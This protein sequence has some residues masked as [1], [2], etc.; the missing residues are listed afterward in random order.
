MQFFWSGPAQLKQGSLGWLHLLSLSV[1]WL[2]DLGGTQMEHLASAPHSL[3]QASLYSDLGL[4]KNSKRKQ[5]QYTHIFQT[6]VCIMFVN[7]LQAKASYMMGG[8]ESHVAK[9]YI[10]KARD[11]ILSIFIIYHSIKHILWYIF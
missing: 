9:E 2:I 8:D 5:A 10:C 7:V 11:N 3:A 4:P 1:Y 6:S